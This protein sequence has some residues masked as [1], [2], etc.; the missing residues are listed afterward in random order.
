MEQVDTQTLSTKTGYGLWIPIASLIVVIALWLANYWVAIDQSSKW[1]ERGQ[2]G[3]LF[4]A[5]NALFSG[6]AFAGIIY[7]I[8]LQRMDLSYQ[9]RVLD[10]TRKEVSLQSETFLKDQFENTFFRLMTVQKE[11]VE[12]IYVNE[13][14]KGQKYLFDYHSSITP[15]LGNLGKECREKHACQR[16]F[17]QSYQTAFRQ[18]LESYFSNIKTI[19][20]FV[21]MSTIKEKKLY[22]SIFYDHLSFPEKGLL[23]YQAALGE[24]IELKRLYKLS[25]FEENVREQDV[26]IR[27]HLSFID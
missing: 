11:T 8:Y 7:T 13:K 23:F 22:L 4:G 14:L 10:L 26:F 17:N 27:E 5:V 18:V 12:K 25:G 2:M 19:L 6:L 24:D 15:V 20:S 16:S 21:H 9:G 1:D 3:D